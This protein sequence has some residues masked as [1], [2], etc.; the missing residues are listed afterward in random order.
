MNT[1]TP[2]TDEACGYASNWDRLNN[3]LRD[4]VPAE[5]A[6][7][8]ERERNE[9]IKQLAGWNALSM[10]GDTPEK[11]WDAWRKRVIKTQKYIREMVYWRDKCK[12]ADPTTTV[13]EAKD[14]LNSF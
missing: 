8:L 7:K 4:E 9:A 13:E 12:Q 11:V 5:F 1:D 10:L 6:R 2:E 3:R 14:I